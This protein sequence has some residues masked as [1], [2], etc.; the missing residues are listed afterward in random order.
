M[1][2]IKHIEYKEVQERL[3]M[4]MHKKTSFSEGGAAWKEFYEGDTTQLLRELSDRTCCEDIADNEGIG[5]MYDFE[6]PMH[7]SMIIGDFIQADTQVPEGLYAKPVPAGLTVQVQIEGEDIGDILN[8]AYGL[9]TEAVKHSGREIDFDHF[10][11]CEVYT[12][13][14]F[15]EPMSRGERVAIDYIMPVRAE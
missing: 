2:I 5:F 6:D 7:F 4:G 12:K 9:I 8:S 15:S 13:E 1:A 11:W 10:Y 14:R 3:M